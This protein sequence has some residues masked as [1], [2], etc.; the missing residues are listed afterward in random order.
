MGVFV[1]Q[2]A[3]QQGAQ[4]SAQQLKQPCAANEQQWK[5]SRECSSKCRNISEFSGSSQ[6]G[7]RHSS[8]CA[9]ASV[10]TAN[11]AAANGAAAQHLAQKWAQQSAVQSTPQ[12]VQQFAQQSVQRVLH[13]RSRE[14]SD[15]VAAVGAAGPQQDHISKRSSLCYTSATASE[16][17]WQHSSE[18]SSGMQHRAQ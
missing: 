7:I 8:G 1:G 12:S 17:Q 2:C 3:A 11:A 15:S 14:R 13:Q 4:P 6:R 5:C 18:R 10:A 9:A 16:Q